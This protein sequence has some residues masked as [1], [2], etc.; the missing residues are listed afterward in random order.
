M[1]EMNEA[2]E[3]IE[4]ALKVNDSFKIPEKGPENLSILKKIQERQQKDK[5]F[6]HLDVI[7]IQHHLGPFIARLNAM[8]DSDLEPGRCWFSHNT[9]IS[10]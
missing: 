1:L 4:R 9:F 10:E 6:A 8:L 2:R 5:P 3:V 7:F